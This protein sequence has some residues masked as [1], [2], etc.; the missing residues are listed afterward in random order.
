MEKHFTSTVSIARSSVAGNKTTYATVATGVACHIQPLSGE[1]AIAEMGRYAKTHLMFSK[2][3]VK[4]GDR[5]TDASGKEY[6]VV[7]SEGHSFRG[8]SHYEANLRAV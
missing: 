3:E 5:L 6:E 8:R 4:V 2:T 1:L 7:S